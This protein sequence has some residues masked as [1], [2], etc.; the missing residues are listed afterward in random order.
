MD[1]KM[2]KMNIFD[3]VRAEMKLHAKGIRPVC[4]MM[5]PRPAGNIS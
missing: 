4:R 5:I 2:F 3:E 1:I